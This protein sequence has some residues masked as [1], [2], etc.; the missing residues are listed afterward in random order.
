MDRY[1]SN[2]V[3]K[4]KMTLKDV[5]LKLKL[6][7]W[8]YEKSLLY[9][10]PRRISRQWYYKRRT[11]KKMDL[12]NPTD[13]NE[14]L[15][16]LIINVYGERESKYADKLLVRD[17]VEEM[18]YSYIL[19][20]VYGVYNKSKEIDFD[21]LPERFVLK[22]NHGSGDG[23]YHIC[24]NK[25]GI[26]SKRVR[27]KLD[28]ALKKNFAKESLEYH[29]A[30]IDRKIICEEFIESDSS[31]GLIDYKVLC[32]HG[33]PEYILVATNRKKKLE[34]LYYD[35]NWKSVDLMK[36]Q[37][38]SNLHVEKPLNLD[39]MLSI[40]KDL[41]SPF[42]FAR[43]DFYNIKGKIYFGE[44]TL[45]PATGINK[46]YSKKGLEILGSKINL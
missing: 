31:N 27:K 7:L 37:Y 46:T 10:L 6:K 8:E 3:R 29:Y 19:P 43:I 41:S 9:Y 45:T 15:Q 4:K 5:T 44:I 32:F 26:D 42:V 1:E 40:A 18:G 35:T 38:E 39:E 14:K 33:K 2:V 11:G 23:F 17:Y 24:E 13:F 36:E 25:S 30:Y 12:N 34:R 28:K 20:K 21:K 22:T 16:W